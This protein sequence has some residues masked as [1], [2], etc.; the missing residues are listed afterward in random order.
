MKAALVEYKGGRCVDCN[1]VFPNC[2][3]H[4]DHRDPFQ[5]EF[6][7]GAKLTNNLEVLKVEADKCDLV[8]A[9]CHA[10]RT[11]GNPLI[12]EKMKV[13]RGGDHR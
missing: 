5:K 1:G 3:Y 6:N 4:F 11:Y 12:A 13:G 7:I 10:I 2:V 9:N 8:C